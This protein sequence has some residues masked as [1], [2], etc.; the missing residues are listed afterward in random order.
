MPHGYSKHKDDG[1]MCMYC[2]THRNGDKTDVIIEKAR[3]GRYN[4]CVE[5]EGQ[6]MDLGQFATKKAAKTEAKNFMRD[7]PKGLNEQKMGGGLPGTGNS[8]N[9]FGL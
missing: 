7:N 3:N 2:K 1:E 9:P 6:T 5:D 8:N 4:A